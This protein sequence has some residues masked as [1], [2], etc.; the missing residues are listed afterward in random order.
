MTHR[1]KTMAIE[2][3]RSRILAFQSCPRQRY[4]AYHHLGKG[5]QK[6]AKGL[7]L[8][9]GSAFHEGAELLLA[10]DIEGAVEK[11]R[12]YLATAFAERGV[13]LDGEDNQTDA[14]LQYAAEEQ[15]ALAEGLTRGWGL[16]KL[17]AFLETFEVIE[18]EREG[19][20]ALHFHPEQTCSN[21][22]HDVHAGGSYC[23]QCGH[24]INSEWRQVDDLVLMFRPDALVRDRAS[25]DLYVVS[26]K[27]CSTYNKRTMDQCRTDMQSMSEV[28]GIE[29]QMNTQSAA[30]AQAMAN[31]LNTT[32]AWGTNGSRIEGVLYLH[33]VKGQRR[34]DDWD[35]FYKQGTPLA[36]GW[37][38][39]GDDVDEW[40][41]AYEWAK[42]DGSGKSKLGKGWKKVPIWRDYPGGVKKWIEDLHNQS[43]FPRHLNALESVFPESLP[44]ERR[45]DE[46]AHWKTQ[47]VAQELKVAASLE[48]VANPVAAN[49]DEWGKDILDIEFPQHTH[50]CH[51]FSG[52]QFL[53]ICWNGV[54]P[55]PGDLYTIRQN[56]HPESGDDE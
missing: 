16:Q 38:K 26:W 30:D 14:A 43:I 45:A 48:R 55:S 12:T 17:P 44:V 3:D 1:R 35:G 9:F 7:P 52:C 33:I 29:Q 8:Q 39:L 34:K 25:G 53:D 50:S 40:S 51:S 36:Y 6:K 13:G 4:L 11:A 42:E 31:L 24:A 46:V 20:A 22:E 27:T 23:P 19:R 2:V 21:C 10:G 41:W 47:V 15:M 56:N 49:A 18:V 54:D 37:K 5:L 28:W 32:V